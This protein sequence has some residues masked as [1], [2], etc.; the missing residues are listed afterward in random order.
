[1]KLL[2]RLEAKVFP[3]L[4]VRPIR[5]EKKKSDPRET[6]FAQS[7]H[8]WPAGGECLSIMMTAPVAL[9][10][11]VLANGYAQLLEHQLV[12]HLTRKIAMSHSNRLWVG[13][14]LAALAQVTSVAMPNS[15]FA[16]DGIRAAY[17]ETVIPSKNYSGYVSLSA[18]T[19]SEASVGPSQAGVF[20]IGSIVLTN[21][22]KIPHSL[23]VGVPN[24]LGGACTGYTIGEG[25]V[26]T[27]MYFNVQPQSTLVIPFPTP[28]V[29]NPGGGQACIGLYDQSIYADAGSSL[30]VLIVGLL[31]Y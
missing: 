13:V 24:L 22:G 30:D 14:C 11:S 27:V 7:R 31:N 8:S 19:N 4:G 2:S 25:F 21:T 3:W 6:R 28:Y 16:A 18:S 12:N 23:A 10:E 29:V 15:A 17:V 20:G 9:L 1:M 5:R 26:G